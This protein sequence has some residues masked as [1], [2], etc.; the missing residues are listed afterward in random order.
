M[1]KRSI[2][3]ILKK[4]TIK[5]PQ[6][7]LLKKP[8]NGQPTADSTNVSLG[9]AA[10][11][12]RASKKLEYQ[13]IKGGLHERLIDHL[14][15]AGMLIR[16]DDELKQHVEEFVAGVL[17]TEDIPLNQ[18]ERIRLAEELLEEALGSGPLAPLM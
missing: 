10:L 3:A 6:D 4:K 11:E 1:T 9:T 17:E 12:Q 15:N 5:V 16:P 8:S 7:R 18:S 13:S 14:N 2:R